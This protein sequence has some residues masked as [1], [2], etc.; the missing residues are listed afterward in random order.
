MEVTPVGDKE[1]RAQSIAARVAM[2][3]VFIPKGLVWD[4]LVDEMLAFPNGTHDD[5]V[6][7]LSLLGLGMQSQTRASRP[8]RRDAPP[9]FGTLAW[10]KLQDK[11][12]AEQKRAAHG[13]F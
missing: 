5:G 9:K 10:V 12:A 1:Q 6:D 3:K 2:G 7:M 4:R 13:G 11:W 8:T